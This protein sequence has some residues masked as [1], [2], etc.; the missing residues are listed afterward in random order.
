MRM[1]WKG[2]R[3][4]WKY[5]CEKSLT[6]F[7][8]VFMLNFNNHLVGYARTIVVDL[9]Y[10]YV[11]LHFFVVI[12]HFCALLLTLYISTFYYFHLISVFTSYELA[13]FSTTE[14]LCTSLNI[15]QKLKSTETKKRT[16]T[17]IERPKC[18]AEKKSIWKVMRVDIMA[19]WKWKS[20]LKCKLKLWKYAM[21]FASWEN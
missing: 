13:N 11:R 9:C 15:T 12:S 5:S 17:S 21:N 14:I 3:V 16:Q 4:F 1:R 19:N 18:R 7:F 2:E 6:Y 20:I 8:T 10:G